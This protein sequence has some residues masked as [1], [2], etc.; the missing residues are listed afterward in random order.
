M[1]I[2]V[3]QAFK[4]AYG[5]IPDGA[6]CHLANWPGPTLPQ[7]MNIEPTIWEDGWPESLGTREDGSP[8]VMEYPFGPDISDRDA[9]A[10]RG[11]FGD[12]YDK[13]LDGLLGAE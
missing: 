12:D 9:E 11:L 1:K 10:F 13:A 2:T 7:F 8:G 4:K 6:T 3:R 5:P